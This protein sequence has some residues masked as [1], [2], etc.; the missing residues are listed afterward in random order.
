[1]YGVLGLFSFF[2][3]REMSRNCQGSQVIAGHS[4]AWN[5]LAAACAAT[6]NFQ[7]MRC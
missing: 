2:N 7:V 4:E 1:M 6:K 5:A 3:F